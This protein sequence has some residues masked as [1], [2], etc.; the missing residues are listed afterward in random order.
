MSSIKY[1]DIENYNREDY[2]IK[3]GSEKNSIE[4]S[5]FIRKNINEEEI[6]IPLELISKNL[7]KGSEPIEKIAYSFDFSNLSCFDF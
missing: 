3:I 1:T 4:L 2:I 6:K 7:Y 5:L